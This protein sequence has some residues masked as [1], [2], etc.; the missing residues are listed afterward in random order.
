MNTRNLLDAEIAA[1]LSLGRAFDPDALGPD[2]LEAA[3]N[4]LNELDRRADPPPQSVERLT[5]VIRN[6]PAL[7]IRVHRPKQ[8]DS[9]KR[10]CLYW[11][12]GGGYVLGSIETQAGELDRWCA[13]FDCIVVSVEYRLAPEHPYPAPLDDCLTALE[14]VFDHIEYLGVEPDQ[15]GIGGTSAGGGLAAALALRVRDEGRH[16]LAFQFLRYPM[17]D[18]R[19]ITPSSQREGVPMWTPGANRFGW[20]SYL[21]ELYGGEVSEY[22]AP[23]RATDFADLPPTFVAVGGL[24][25]F[26]DENID[27]A[28]RL[29][30]AD[31]PTELHV[32]A[33]APH[34]FVHTAPSSDLVRRAVRETDEWLSRFL[35]R[36]QT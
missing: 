9:N 6:D 2:T 3:R 29:M 22:A 33:G 31:V 5:H 21:G 16:S 7:E 8:M 35:R 14:W 19:Q 11:M 18:D 17:L 10:G 20:Q 34:G 13:L 27:Y 25:G 36:R 26:L 32:Y 28:Q 12:H 23:A 15:I 24:D 30:R 4:A 1:A